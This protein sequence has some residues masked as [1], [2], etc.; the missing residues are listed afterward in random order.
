MIDKMTEE[1]VVEDPFCKAD[2]EGFDNAFWSVQGGDE[3][4]KTK[5][6]FYLLSGLGRVMVDQDAAVVLLEERVR[7]RDAQAEWMLGLC[8]DFGFGT[9]QNI[10]R[11]RELYNQ[12]YL[13][14]CDAGRVLSS[15]RMTSRT[16]ID[17]YSTWSN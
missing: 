9:E 2:K 8:Y 14:G 5:L 11:A 15:F 17:G 3:K 13:H 12:S 7:N 10:S 1:C 4:A 6:A 16:S